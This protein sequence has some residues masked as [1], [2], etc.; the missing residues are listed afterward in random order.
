[1]NTLERAWIRGGAEKAD[2]RAAWAAGRTY[3]V[4]AD[5]GLVI[6]SVGSSL[7]AEQLTAGTRIRRARPAGRTGA[8]EAV[9]PSWI[10]RRPFTA[11]T[12]A[13]WWAFRG[14]PAMAGRVEA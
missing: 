7:G 4:R 5:G 2:A 8:G 6:G 11:A 13:A 3:T 1:M 12:R 10:V 9:P 14:C